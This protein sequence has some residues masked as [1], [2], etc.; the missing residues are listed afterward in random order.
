M[1]CVCVLRQVRFTSRAHAA[2]K[3]QAEAEAEATFQ[4]ML[5]LTK[6]DD[7]N[8]DPDPIYILPED[9]STTLPSEASSSVSE[10]SSK[11]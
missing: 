7:D 3:D 8:K 4:R 6:K 9:M 10:S 5:A 11:S 2:A 1:L